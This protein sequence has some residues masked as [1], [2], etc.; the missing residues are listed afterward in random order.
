M[1]FE[2]PRKLHSFVMLNITI[3]TAIDFEYDKLHVRYLIDL[4]DSCELIEGELFGST[5]SSMRNSKGIWNF[6]HPFSI[7][8][9]CP[10]QHSWKGKIIL[11]SWHN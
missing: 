7:T 2:N 10:D 5:I 9:S 8:F 4:P 6:G 3:Q 11:V 1:A